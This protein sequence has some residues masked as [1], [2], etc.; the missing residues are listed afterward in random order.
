MAGSGLFTCNEKS[1]TEG[2]T[3]NQS[4]AHEPLD[5]EQKTRLTLTQHLAFK[6]ACA[7]VGIKQADV[8]RALILNFVRDHHRQTALQSLGLQATSAQATD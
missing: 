2:H 8:M 6:T 4:M 7:D 1:H 3:M 5:I